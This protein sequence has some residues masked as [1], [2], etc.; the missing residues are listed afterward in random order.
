MPRFSFRVFPSE[1]VE[2]NWVEVSS[3]SPNGNVAANS[4]FGGR[5]VGDDVVVRPEPMFV[6]GGKA[7]FPKSVPQWIAAIYVDDEGRAALGDD[8]RHKTFQL[9]NN[10]LREFPLPVFPSPMPQKVGSG[11]L[12][13]SGLPNLENWVLRQTSTNTFVGYGIHT[14]PFDGPP[15]GFRYSQFALYEKDGKVVS[16]QSLLQGDK[17]NV[18]LEDGG[19]ANAA[20]T[21]A[22]SGTYKNRPAI[23]I[24]KPL[25]DI[26]RK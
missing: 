25:Q 12:S 10:V 26:G 6:V 15:N 20:G 22:A 17:K 8:T 11:I 4:W 9:E 14:E 7:I 23:F 13:V 24:L 5:Y 18:V 21:I 3:I 2:A 16:L 19:E 1:A